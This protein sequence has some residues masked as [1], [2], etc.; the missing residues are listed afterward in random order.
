MTGFNPFAI[1][2]ALGGRY[3]WRW[4][5]AVAVWLLTGLAAIPVL[6]YRGMSYTTFP[7]TVLVLGIA[8]SLFLIWAWGSRFAVSLG[9]RRGHVFLVTLVASLALPWAAYLLQMTV[10]RL[11]L[12]AV[13]RDGQRAFLTSFPDTKF[14]SEEFFDMFFVMLSLMATPVAM[15]AAAVVAC[16]MRWRLPG[17]LLA[18]AGI[19]ILLYLPFAIS[20]LFMFTEPVPEAVFYL[21]FAAVS[22]ACLAV[23]WV[24]FKKQPV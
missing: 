23:A 19:G 14:Y 11:E 2:A 22:L 7:A 8:L 4:W 21:F 18:A 9:H 6:M 10:R 24:A 3:Q 16:G 13:G 17:A 12:L 1:L 20:G 15:A 5:G